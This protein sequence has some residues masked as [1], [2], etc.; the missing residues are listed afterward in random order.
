MAKSRIY[1]WAAPCPT[2]RAGKDKPCQD[3]RTGLRRSLY[4]RRTHKAR[5]EAVRAMGNPR[6]IPTRYK[7]ARPTAATIQW[8]QTANAINVAT[9]Q[10]VTAMNTFTT[11]LAN[12]TITTT[13]T[14][15]AWT[16]TRDE[17]W[18]S[19]I[20]LQNT[21]TGGVVRYEYTDEQVQTWNRWNEVHYEQ[22]LAPAEAVRVMQEELDRQQAAREERN[23]QMLAEAQA[24]SVQRREAHD[25]AQELFLSLL[26]DEQRDQWAQSQAIHVRGSAGGL[27]ELRD[28][29]VHGNISQIDEHGCRLATLCVAPS[30]RGDDYQ[31][32]PTPDGWVGQLL[33][34]RHNEEELV[35]RANFS[36]RR[37]CQYPNVPILGQQVA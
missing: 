13:A 32:L 24:I 15:G 12:T 4:G 28:G 16:V 35:A 36:Y 37:Q 29:G 19:W 18:N 31:A 3:Q 6:V 14:T 23:R 7:L 30:M 8:Q 34:I 9:T 22:V 10:Y 26:T 20:N 1:V 27:Y 11:A 5:A 21:T 17:M 25:R 33:A 2:C